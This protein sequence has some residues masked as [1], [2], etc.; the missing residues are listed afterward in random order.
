M[1]PRALADSKDQ[2]ESHGGPWDRM[3]KKVDGNAPDIGARVEGM[4]HQLQVRRLVNA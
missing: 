3:K 1:M 2:A 4:G